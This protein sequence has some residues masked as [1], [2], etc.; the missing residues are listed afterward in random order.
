[1]TNMKVTKEREDLKIME[2]T[3][4]QKRIN[5]LRRELLGL[6]LN[7]ATAHVKDYSQFSKLRKQI[8]RALTEQKSRLVAQ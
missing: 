4:L 8:A 2:P 7:A 5:S 6:R 3:E 1:M